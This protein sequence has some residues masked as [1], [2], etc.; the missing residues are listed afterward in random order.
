MWTLKEAQAL[1]AD[2][3][4]LM[5][6][7]HYHTLLGGG[8]LHAGASDHDLDIFFFPLNGYEKQPRVIME[9]LFQL[10]EGMRPIRD[11]PD[12]KAGEP[13]YVTEMYRG[14]FDGK[15]VDLFVL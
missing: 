13:Y 7:Q 14:T 1:I 6:E 3:E 4:P 9:I 8:V 15:R 5:R 2:I 12:Y 11:S 10:F